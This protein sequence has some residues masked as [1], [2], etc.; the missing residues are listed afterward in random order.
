MST[1]LSYIAYIVLSR[2]AIWG[3]VIFG[4]Y[5][6]N[7]GLATIVI[8]ILGISMQYDE[9]DPERWVEIFD[10]NGEISDEDEE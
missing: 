6:F 1:S 8:V 9:I 2:L 4:C 5:W 3:S 10:P 7:D